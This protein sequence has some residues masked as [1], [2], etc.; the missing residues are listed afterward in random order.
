MSTKRQ[1]MGY[2]KYKHGYRKENMQP[3]TVAQVLLGWAFLVGMFSAWMLFINWVA[4]V[5]P[6]EGEKGLGCGSTLTDLLNKEGSW[7]LIAIILGML[8]IFVSQIISAIKGKQ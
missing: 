2:W 1:R 8:T 6:E 7:I 3:Q 5:L 4:C